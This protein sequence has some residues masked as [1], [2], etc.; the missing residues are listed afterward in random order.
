MRRYLDRARS[1]LLS[2]LLIFFLVPAQ[3]LWAWTEHPLVIHETLGVL[4]EVRDAKQVKVESLDAFLM[5]EEKGLVALLESEEAWAR[6]NLAWYKP[7]PNGLEFKATGNSNDI[8][9]RFAHAIR[10]NPHARLG[11][12]LQFV[13]GADTGGK[14]GITPDRLT[15]LK[16]ISEWKS[17]TFAELKAGE[18]VSPLDIVTTASDEPDFGLD[19]GLYDDND[20]EFGKT[21][22][23]GKQPFGNPNLE[24]SSQGPFHMGYYHEAWIVNTYPEYRIHLYK[25][26]SEYAFRTGHDYW[27]WRFMGI[28]LHYVIDLS[29]PYH[30]TL[31]PGV[32]TIEMLWIN[33]LNMIGISGPMNNAIQLVSNRHTAIEKFQQMAMQE[34]Y[35]Q[36]NVDYP[37]FVALRSV[38]ACPAWN[39]RISRDEISAKSNALSGKADKVMEETMPQRWVSDPTF[40][41]GTSPEQDDIMAIM[42][43]KDGD[44]GI[45]KNTDLLKDMLE[46]LP[47]YT[48]SYVRGILVK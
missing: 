41:L 27:G 37:V 18:M 5:A 19:I 45:D 40:E 38:K 14:P 46:P 23:F 11:L 20:T 21:Y 36:K 1:L 6:Q 30:T 22:G 35:R 25:S 12:Y 10:I 44:K 7:L 8:R 15:F 4:P 39:D 24:Y 17:T 43:Q 3:M 33:T 34:A 42:K 31:L 29:L 2:I 47:G 13:P 16:D 26:L 9:Q 48:C 28:G 32:S